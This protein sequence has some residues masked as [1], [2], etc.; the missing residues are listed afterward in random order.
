MDCET[1][2]EGELVW[3]GNVDCL[4]WLG[5]LLFRGWGEAGAVG[6]E[7]VE[8]VQGLRVCQGGKS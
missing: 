8:H 3:W 4:W 2:D 6:E 7:G 5:A 1:A